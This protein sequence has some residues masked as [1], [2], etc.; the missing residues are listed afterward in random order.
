LNIAFYELLTRLDLSEIFEQ[1]LIFSGEN[2][3]IMKTK[4]R[5]IMVT[6]FDII[7]EHAP[8]ELAIYKILHGKVRNTGHKTISLLVVN[9]FKQMVGVVSMFDILYHLRPDFLNYGIEGDEIM[10]KGQI[11]DLISRLEN[12]SINEIMSS[13]VI[14]ASPDEHIIVLLDRMVKHKYRRL[15]IIENNTPIGMV[16]ISDI[17]YHLFHK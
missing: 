5:E 13:H 6:N 1:L 3:H 9:N 15:P 10:W 17:Y 11:E 14:G 16:Y 8:V 4:A 12:K 7:S 2:K